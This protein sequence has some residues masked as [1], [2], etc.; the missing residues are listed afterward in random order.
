MHWILAACLLLSIFTLKYYKVLNHFIDTIYKLL[1]RSIVGKV[2]LARLFVVAKRAGK[3]GVQRF[4]VFL[5][6][7]WLSLRL[8]ATHTS[9]GA[10]I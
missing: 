9:F 7:F 5:P 6:R 2:H 10:Q 3:L 8:P 1:L 4:D